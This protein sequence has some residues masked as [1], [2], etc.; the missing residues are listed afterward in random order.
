MFQTIAATIAALLII[1]TFTLSLLAV[2]QNT[3]TQQTI[4][5]ILTILKLS[6]ERL[7]ILERHIMQMH[8][9]LISGGVVGEP[10]ESKEMFG[11]AD[12]KHMATTLEELIQKILIDPAYQKIN[13]EEIE[14]LKNLFEKE[15]REGDDDFPPEE[16]SSD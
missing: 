6:H 9:V 5:E 10:G 3:G 16:D 14:K 12:G 7:S 8:G 13:P 1:T 4:K 11:S 15:N 2:L